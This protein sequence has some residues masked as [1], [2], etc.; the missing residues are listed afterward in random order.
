M[1]V[2]RK[3]KQ[4]P[5]TME[6]E[7]RLVERKRAAGNDRTG[8]A[9]RPVNPRRSRQP[10]EPRVGAAVKCTRLAALTPRRNSD[11]GGSVQALYLSSQLSRTERSEG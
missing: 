11:S 7:E 10:H 5:E 4:F 2:F 8:G 1:E 6:V 9:D 3:R